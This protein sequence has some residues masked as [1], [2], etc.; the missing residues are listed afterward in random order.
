MQTL[1]YFNEQLSNDKT[2][3]LDIKDP[4]EGDMH[5][6][7]KLEDDTNINESFTRYN[8]LDAYNAQVIIVNV[9]KDKEIITPSALQLGTYGGKYKL[10]LKYR[11]SACDDND[12]RRI[13]VVFY[14]T[15][16]GK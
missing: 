11:L 8:I 12:V 5:F 2:V 13:K 4:V 1:T 7:I 15:E 14:I 16:K 3:R 6:T 9:P 10:S